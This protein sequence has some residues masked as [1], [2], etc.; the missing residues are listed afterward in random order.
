MLPG[1][2]AVHF[3]Q[4]QG[5]TPTCVVCGSLPE[6]EAYAREQVKGREAL[7]CRVYDH[8]GFVGAPIL[9]ITGTGFKGESDLSPRIRRWT[10]ALLLALGLGLCALDWSTG[11]RLS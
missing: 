6:A 5:P 2:Y 11:F 7:R 8:Q 4:Q 3:S 10:G 1:E 9:E